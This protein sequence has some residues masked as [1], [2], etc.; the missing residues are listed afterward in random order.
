MIWIW[1]IQTSLGRCNN[2]HTTIILILSCIAYIHTAIM[3]FN[4]FHGTL[5]IQLQRRFTKYLSV[6]STRQ[7]KSFVMVRTNLK[8]MCLS[9]YGVKLWNTLPDDI[10]NCTSVNILKAKLSAISSDTHKLHYTPKHHF[11]I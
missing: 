4:L 1:K 11:I 3:M 8:A 2:L 9:V 6:H 10:K 7:N 5:P